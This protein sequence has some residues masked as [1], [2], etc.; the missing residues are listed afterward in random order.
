MH[1]QRM[2]RARLAAI[3]NAHFLVANTATW[4]IVTACQRKAQIDGLRVAEAVLALLEL[5]AI[6]DG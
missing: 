1:G 2:R 6:G 5:V 3:G 4:E